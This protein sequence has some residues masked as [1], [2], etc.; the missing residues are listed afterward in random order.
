M[1]PRAHRFAQHFDVR[2]LVDAKRLPVAERTVAALK[3]AAPGTP[4]EDLI[5]RDL[6]GGEKASG[7]ALQNRKA[8]FVPQ[9]RKERVR[10]WQRFAGGNG[11]DGAGV[12]PPRL[13]VQGTHHDC[14]VVFIP[15]NHNICFLLACRWRGS[16]QAFKNS[17][18][19]TPK[20]LGKEV[21]FS[22]ELAIPRGLRP[23]KTS[24]HGIQF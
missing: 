19:D 3:V 17:A 23:N 16:E 10:R 7:G 15:M 22:R 14:A 24:F 21:C 9:T 13:L 8:A 11:G 5:D 20:A 12:G 4:V 18:A 1:A 6:G 2:L